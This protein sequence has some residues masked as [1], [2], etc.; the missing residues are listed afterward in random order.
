MIV[1]TGGTTGRPKGV[2]LTG[3]NL[4]TMTAI[5]LMSYPFGSRPVYLALAPLTHAAGVLCFPIMA[6]GGEIVVMR[7]PDVGEF[8]RPHQ[9]ARGDAHLP[10]ADA[11]LHGAGQ[12]VL[13][14]TELSSLQ[15]FWYGAAPM[16]ADPAR[17]GALSHR[18]GDGAAV[19]PDRGADDDLDHGAPRPLPRRRK[20]RP[21]T[22]VISGASRSAGDGHHHGGGR[23]PPPARRARRGRHPQLAGDARLPPQPR[24][25]RG[26]VGP[27]LAPHR[28][29]RLPRRG[30]LPL[31]RR[32]RQG[33]GH[34]R[35][36][37]RLLHRGRAGR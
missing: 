27:R 18:P 3:T 4:E 35:R 7:K 23:R 36:L 24:G 15:C 28:R 13:D 10:A 8:L 11:D 26:G 19:R 25:H 17:G 1:G 32:P 30:R 20:R 14:T 29:H 22:T 2:L 12:P 31:P 6:L 21:R 33:H 9:R 37:Q 5:T 16:S 34:H